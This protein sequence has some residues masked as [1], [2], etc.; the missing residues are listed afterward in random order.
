MCFVVITN[1]QL[2]LILEHINIPLLIPSEDWGEKKLLWVVSCKRNMN[3]G[4]GT[5]HRQDIKNN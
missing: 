2:S 3:G 4:T 1:L 5:P